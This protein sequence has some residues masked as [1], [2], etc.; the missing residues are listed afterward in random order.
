VTVAIENEVTAGAPESSR[1]KR[2]LTRR[3]IMSKGAS[4]ATDSAGALSPLVRRVLA[5][6]GLCDADQVQRFCRPKLTDLHD[7]GLMPGIDVAATRIIDAV[8]RDEHI[9]IYGDYDADGISATAIL[10]HTIKTIQPNA[11]IQT[12][13]PHRLDEGYGLNCDALKHLRSGGANLVVCVDCGVTAVESAQTARQIGLDLII[14]DHH[15]LK[16]TDESRMTNEESTANA[17]AQSSLAARHSPLLPDALAIVHPSLPGSQYPFA[18]LCG[19]GVAFKLAWRIATL[20]CNSQRVSEALQKTLVSMLPLAALATI[21]DVVPLIGE[22]RIIAAHGLRLIRQTP[23]PGLRALIEASGLMDE[24]IDSHKVGF[25]LAPRLNACGRMGNA[26]AAVR[27][28]TDAQPDEAAAIARRLSQLNQQRQ[29][30]E[31]NIFEQAAYLAED[32]GMT[33]DGKRAIVLAHETWHA[34]VVG[35]ACSRM[36]ERFGRP[37]ILLQRSKDT[38]KGSARSID[39]YSIHEGLSAVARHLTSFG[40]HAMAAGLSLSSSNLDAFAEALI[41]HANQRIEVEQLTPSITID[42]AAALD[43]LDVT[44]IQ[45]LNELSPFG[46]GNR[47]P[48]LLVEGVTLT[49]PPRQ[50]GGGGKHLSMRV[51]QDLGGREGSAGGRWIRAVWWSAGHRAADLAAGMRLDIAIEPKLNEWQ[52]R[53]SVE[54]ELKDLRIV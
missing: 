7:P 38:C 2:G 16:Q 49:E 19:A 25:M 13:V 10:Y 24:K 1:P 35:I 45:S 46:R 15:A 50:I 48:M 29:G 26:A 18:E 44:A 28:L 17:D 30:V 11:R 21:A 51:R 6:R 53:V 27:M 22:N 31:R 40:G 23:L 41:E 33:T 3:W 12:Y 14:T 54:A 20:W 34:G 39:G 9:V 4:P 37:T 43:E 36:V 5:A 42:C 47:T 8:K 52:G 32:R